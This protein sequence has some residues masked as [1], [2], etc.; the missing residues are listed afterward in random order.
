MQSTYA[1][2]QSQSQSQPVSLAK[3]MLVIGFV[4]ILAAGSTFLLIESSHP[5]APVAQKSLHHAAIAPNTG[6]APAA[7]S[8]TNGTHHKSN[9][10]HTRHRSTAK[11]S[12]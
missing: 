11:R 4:G 6:K 5:K 7:Q 8:K 1:L 9:A 3:P 2:R 10:A 12:H